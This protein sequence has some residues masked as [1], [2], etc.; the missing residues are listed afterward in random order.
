VERAC[1]VGSEQGGEL[2]PV[3]RLR[4]RAPI[5]FQGLSDEPAQISVVF[6][7]DRMKPGERRANGNA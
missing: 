3:F 2:C 4:D 5:L 6:G 1:S 7:D